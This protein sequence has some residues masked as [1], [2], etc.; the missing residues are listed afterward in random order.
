MLMQALITGD[1]LY[2]YLHCK[3]KGYLKLHGEYGRKT[4][5][6]LLHQ[7]SHDA[8]KR[9]VTHTMRT[10]YR[11]EPILQGC[12]VTPSLLQQG[13]T[14]ILDAMINTDILSFHI[15]GLQRVP[16]ASQIGPFHYM[17]ILVHTGGK[18]YEEQRLL[19]TLWSVALAALQGRQPEKGRIVYGPACKASTVQLS[20]RL[21]K[22]QRVLEELRQTATTETPVMLRLNNH[23][24]LCEFQDRCQRQAMEADDLSL[25]RGMSEKEITQHNRRGIF[26]T[27]QLSYTF[28]ARK[29]RKGAHQSK[30]AHYFALQ[31]LAIR[32]QQIYVFGMPELP[33]SPVRIYLDLEGA[34]D[35]NFVYLL[36]MII[37]A[38]GVETRYAFWADH[39]G[40][41]RMI[42]RQ[43]LE[44]VKQY[45]SYT[46]FHYGNYER[47]F[48]KRM[49]TYAPHKKLVE[50]VITHACNVLSLIYAHI[51]FP[52]Y[53]NGL[54]EI[55]RYVGCH[56]TE[57]DASGVQSLVWRQQW[58][59]TGDDV[60]KQKLLIYNAEDCMALQR[61]TE[62]LSGIRAQRE[63]SPLPQASADQPPDVVW[64]QDMSAPTSRG[65]WGRAQ[66]FYPDFDYIN[67]CAYF[68]YQREKVFIRTSKTIRKA[69]IQ[70]RKMRKSTRLKANKTIE[71]KSLTCPLCK[72]R[73]ISRN[74]D[75][76]HTK[77]A[78]DLQLTPS[79]IRR[80]ITACVTTQHQCGI[81]RKRF[82]PH[83]YKQRD[84]HFHTLKSWAMY[85]HVVHRISFQNLEEIL[86]ESFGLRVGYS[87][88]HMFKALLAH[89]YRT[90]YKRLLHKILNGSLI[91]VDETPITLQRSKGYV[92]VLTNLE[93]VVFLYRR[94]R[95]GGFLR[96]WLKGYH[97]VVISDF[98]S[99][100]DTL[101]CAQQ[102]CLIHLMRDFNHDLL[103]HAYDEEFK[104]LASEFCSV[105][106]SIVSTIDRYG[107]Q[108]FYL[109][110]HMKDVEHFFK[111]IDAQRYTS[112]IATK[113]QERLI[114]Y[115]DRLFAFIH[116]DG[117]PWN[118]NNAEHAIR[119]L[120]NYRGISN[121]QMTEL[122]LGDY[123]IL[124][125]LYQTCR[126][127]GL[128]FLQFLLSRERD[129][130][131]F[132][133]REP[134]GRRVSSLDVY[135]KGFPWP[136][137]KNHKR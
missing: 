87:E 22:A 43:F 133:A 27:M 77:L 8:F 34:P 62:N 38:H 100:Y 31:A 103:H 44:I 128:R 4:E 101:P 5:Y 81:C 84:K 15:D 131:M 37:D 129:I 48:L 33:T 16:G 93:E 53:T 106:R 122:G 89:Y 24:R 110:K 94:T 124:L 125:S 82:L 64:V 72:G 85:Q 47:T 19:L 46:L 66:F 39:P 123:L 132:A 65:S 121:G 83:R 52:T 12:T 51:Y 67:K 9:Q 3:Y 90:T 55:G 109:N 61:L 13:A 74:Y 102:K 105:L 28:R 99:A 91:H 112:E 57:E 20:A 11:D 25:L 29:P 35:R 95:E 36:G 115:Q 136:Y 79:G 71:I 120:V 76:I 130:D 10:H 107:L 58:E 88:L 68:D 26:T 7:A 111:S 50:Q 127:K 114:K 116:Y 117:V 60:Y 119:H 73:I 137:H 2:S 18:L 6:E 134:Q 63:G 96:E 23:C 98:Y 30:P 41:E 86:H 118:N 40:Q 49:R 113:Y 21:P 69:S 14:I 78:F 75:N 70:A 32:Q 80:R 17:P 45:E 54:K 42:F 1:M 59:M 97:G 108:K 126:Y 92:W 56:W 104:V 135:P